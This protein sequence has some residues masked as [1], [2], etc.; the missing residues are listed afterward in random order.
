VKVYFYGDEKKQD[1]EKNDVF[2]ISVPNFGSVLEVDAGTLAIRG[3]S[4]VR[5]GDYK[6]VLEEVSRILGIKIEQKGREYEG[7]IPYFE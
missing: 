2:A 4:K 6:G 3:E 1:G 7:F 5:R